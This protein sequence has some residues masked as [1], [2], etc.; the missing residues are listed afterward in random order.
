MTVWHVNTIPFEALREF[1]ASTT[2][3]FSFSYS[4]KLISLHCII[5]EQMYLGS[6]HSCYVALLHTTCFGNFP[7]SLIYTSLVCFTLLCFNVK[8]FCS[9]RKG[10][11]Q[12]HKV[13]KRVM[14][15]RVA[16]EILSFFFTQIIFLS[17]FFF[18]STCN[19]LALHRA[20][21]FMFLSILCHD[22]HHHI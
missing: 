12:Q 17:H 15:L 5:T 10:L 14:H 16:K 2:C 13:Y 11:G 3:M 19:W 18:L 6:P 21:S 7:I 4:Q 1:E 20:S 8:P 9:K 22:G